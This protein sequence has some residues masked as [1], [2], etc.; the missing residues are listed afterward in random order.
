ML[1]SWMLLRRAIKPERAKELS[2]LRGLV[3]GR[4]LNPVE[5]A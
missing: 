1:W 2:A 3:G 4:E 5:V